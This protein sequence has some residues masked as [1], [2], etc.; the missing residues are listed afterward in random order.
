MP[1]AQVAAAEVLPWDSE[2]WGHTIGRVAGETLTGAELAEIDAW[3]GENGVECLY[4]LTGADDFDSV[5]AAEDGGFRLVEVRITFRRPIHT[6]LYG[7]QR[8]PAESIT[9]RDAE[10]GDLDEL[11]RIGAASFGQSRFYVDPQFPDQRVDE[12]YGLW[13]EKSMQG[14]KGDRM[15]VAEVAGKPAGFITVSLESERVGRLNLLALDPAIMAS[16]MAGRVSYALG[17][18]AMKF[19]EIERCPM[20]ATTQG[21]NVR[22]QRFIQRWGFHIERVELYFHKWFTP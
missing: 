22:A 11:R 10:P 7:K 5:R 15:I 3:A 16:P 14:W 2:F 18:E 20:R 6:G 4:F 17:L 13:V 9:I 21:A 1:E 12:Y 8:P 19:T